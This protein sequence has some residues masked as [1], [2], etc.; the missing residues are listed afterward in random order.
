MPDF[1]SIDPRELSAKD[2]RRYIAWRILGS[3]GKGIQKQLAEECGCSEASISADMDTV[4]YMTEAA[5]VFKSFIKKQLLPKAIGNVA[6]H[7]ERESKGDKT[8]VVSLEMLKQYGHL[9]VQ[10]MPG[11][12]DN[13]ARTLLDTILHAA[14]PEKE[15]MRRELDELKRRVGALNGIG[16]DVLQGL[17]TTHT[18]ENDDSINDST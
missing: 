11:P 10:D 3:P 8:P 18:G 9:L 17:D 12:E 4:E 16:A 14:D 7:M 2:R 13:T 5:E 6:R 1:T 15:A